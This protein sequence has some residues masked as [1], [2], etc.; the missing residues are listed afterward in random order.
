MQAKN[1]SEVRQLV[2]AF[3][4]DSYEGVWFVFDMDFTL[5]KPQNSKVLLSSFDACLPKLKEQHPELKEKTEAVEEI[6]HEIANIAVIDCES[7]FVEDETLPF[8]KYL[9]NK[10][11]VFMILTNSL[12]GKLLNFDRVEVTRHSKCIKLGLSFSELFNEGED[13][14]ELDFDSFRGNKPRF[15]KGVLYCNGASLKGCIFCAFLNEYLRKGN[16]LPAKI[17]F[18][19]DTDKHVKSVQDDLAKDFPG[20]AYLGI[21]YTYN[22]PTYI[23]DE[24]MLAFW[25]DLFYKIK[26]TK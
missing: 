1:I 22:M 8:I 4:G 20:I 2:D 14:F 5:I 18:V 12:S 26:A 13:D 25:N 10:G 7:A 24:Q 21:T 6:L 11:G 23:I 17:V 3:C 9:H 15:Y 19:D 16:K